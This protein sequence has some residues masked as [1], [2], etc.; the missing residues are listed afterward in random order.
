VISLFK[1][2]ATTGDKEAIK[3]YEDLLVERYLTPEKELLYADML[4]EVKRSVSAR[5]KVSGHILDLKLV[6]L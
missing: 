6:R 1:E 4:E 5:D 3:T 2:L